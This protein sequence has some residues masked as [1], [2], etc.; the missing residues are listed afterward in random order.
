M[1]GKPVRAHQ[2]LASV[3]ATSEEQGW[4]HIIYF[5]LWGIGRGSDWQHAVEG[6]RGGRG[7]GWRAEVRSE[8]GHDASQALPK[9]VGEGD[10]S[11]AGPEGPMAR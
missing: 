3:D 10:P 7:E 6:G 8:I 4:C 11:Q 5:F 1:D 9:M 2:I